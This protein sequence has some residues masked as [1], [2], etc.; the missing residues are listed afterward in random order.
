MTEVT[1]AQ[2]LGEL[3]SYLITGGIICYVIYRVLS[4]RKRNKKGRED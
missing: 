4:K 1:I 3:T 2:I